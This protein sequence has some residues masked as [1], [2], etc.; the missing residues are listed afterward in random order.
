MR[1]LFIGL[2]VLLIAIALALYARH[3]PG[4]IVVQFRGWT[5][6]ASLVLTAAALLVLFVALYYVTRFIVTA[7]SLPRRVGDWRR[8]RR[9][10]RALADMDAGYVDLLEGRWERAERRLMQ[11][12]DV[13]GSLIGWLG[14]ARAAQEQGAVVRR[15]RYLQHA[16]AN[17]PA[18]EFALA[19]TQAEMQIA[20]AQYAQA[21]A[22]LDRLH[23]MAA[24]N[25]IVLTHMMR[26]RLQLGD[27]ER[28]LEMLPR[29][30]RMRLIEEE[31][32]DRIEQ[33]A[34]VGVLE[35]P[36]LKDE[37]DLGAAWARLPRS[38]RE[39]EEPLRRYAERLLACGAADRAEALLRDA[40]DRHWSPALVYLYGLVDAAEPE[41]QLRAAEHWLRRHPQDPVLLLTA[42]RLSRRG[43]LW[44]KARDYLESSL[45]AGGPPEGFSELA[46]VLEEMGERDAA[47]ACYRRA[48]AALE[49]QSRRALAAAGETGLPAPT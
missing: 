24:K 25:P 5:I 32:S 30:R 47:I 43:G 45:R 17:M 7:F 4:Y 10:R 18:A 20:R 21:S 15:D 16:S 40:L 33:R 48:S 14:A 11:S 23:G 1:R 22:T 12:T 9:E 36:V 28:L 2:T 34:A 49:T 38:A 41:R 35:N 27:W 46:I 26:L 3:D 37:H 44:G 6:E 42:G 31:Q 39:R 29:L 13:S 19:L 8:R